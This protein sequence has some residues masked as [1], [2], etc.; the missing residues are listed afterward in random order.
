MRE[1]VAAN[2]K[3][4]CEVNVKAPRSNKH[5]L[6][7]VVDTGASVSIPPEAVY[8]KHFSHC[9]SPKSSLLHMQKR[10]YPLLVAYQG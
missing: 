3:V 9:L 5:T 1:T 8:K 7:L 10:T 2:D 6:Q 4:T